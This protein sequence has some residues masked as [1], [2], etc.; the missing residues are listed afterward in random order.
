MR[1]N[2]VMKAKRTTGPSPN[3]ALLT[4]CKCERCSCGNPAA[5]TRNVPR[6]GTIVRVHYCRSCIGKRANEKPR[7]QRES[8]DA[9]GYI[10]RLFSA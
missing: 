4:R 3:T 5:I 2:P 7:E 9:A 1:G 10:A 6:G 8:F